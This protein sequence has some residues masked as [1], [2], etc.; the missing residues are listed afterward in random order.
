MTE[1]RSLGSASL[2]EAMVA[3]RTHTPGSGALSIKPTNIVVSPFG[4]WLLAQGV[5][6]EKLLQLWQ[7]DKYAEAMINWRREY[8]R[9]KIAPR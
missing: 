6:S 9:S 2:L 1:D 4:D 3:I 8:E 7:D 5:T